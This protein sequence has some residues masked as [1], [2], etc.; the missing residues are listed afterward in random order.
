M[1]AMIEI[2]SWMVERIMGT[3]DRAISRPASGTV[4]SISW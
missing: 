2:I 3:R 1:S 4:R